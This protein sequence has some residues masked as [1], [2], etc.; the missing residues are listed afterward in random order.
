MKRTLVLVSLALLAFIALALFTAVFNAPRMLDSYA[1]IE[2]AR[3]H[4]AAAEAMQTQVEATMVAVSGMVCLVGILGILVMGGLL[5]V[6]WFALANG[7]NPLS[8]TPNSPYPTQPKQSRLRPS[9]QPIYQPPAQP[10]V[11][12]PVDDFDWQSWTWPEDDF[13]TF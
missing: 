12:L 3:A 13:P 6:A 4:Q 5:P 10:T 9:V 11:W 8:V 2:T 7:R 1:E